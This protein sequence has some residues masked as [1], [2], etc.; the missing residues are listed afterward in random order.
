MKVAR[1]RLILG[2]VLAG[3]TLVFALIYTLSFFDASLAASTG[4]GYALAAIAL[5]IV[6]FVACVKLRSVLVAGILTLSGIIMMVAPV[7]AI[8]AAG[9]VVIPGPILGVI[10]YSII[11]VLGVAK[12][13]GLRGGR[14]GSISKSPPATS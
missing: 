6:A 14:A 5:S 1:A 8:A 10:S 9:A 11:L 2:Q 3:L 7:E 4:R 12:A 13:A